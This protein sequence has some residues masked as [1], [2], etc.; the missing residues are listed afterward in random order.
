MLGEPP[1]GLGS[2]LLQE[3]YLGQLRTMQAWVVLL[4]WTLLRA[5][6]GFS[7][8]GYI[9]TEDYKTKYL[10]DLATVE[11]G[12]EKQLVSYSIPPK[13]NQLSILL[14]SDF[15]FPDQ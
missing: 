9:Q 14:K 12:N 7:S 15:F 6:G 13:Q 11:D 4:F 8:Y 5:T 2:H 3:T 10:K 1:H